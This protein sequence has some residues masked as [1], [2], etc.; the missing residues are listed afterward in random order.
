MRIE[1]IF[2]AFSF[3]AEEL[4][5]VAFTGRIFERIFPVAAICNQITLLTPVQNNFQQLDIPTEDL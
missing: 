2:V 4:H 5:Q 3:A 1:L